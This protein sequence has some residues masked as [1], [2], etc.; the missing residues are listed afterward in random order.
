[1][2]KLR[3]QRTIITITIM[4]FAY[5]FTSHVGLVSYTILEITINYLLANEISFFSSSLFKSVY[6]HV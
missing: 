4:K 1:M 3:Q 6:S 2:K 5:W